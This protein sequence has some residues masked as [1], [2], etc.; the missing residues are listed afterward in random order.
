[1]TTPICSR[2]HTH[3]TKLRRMRGRHLQNTF[4]RGRKG[5]IAKRSCT[6]FPPSYPPC[7][8]GEDAD[9]GCEGRRGHDGNG[10]A[11]KALHVVPRH[12]VHAAPPAVTSRTVATRG[13]WH[14]GGDG[15]GE[16]GGRWLTPRGPT[17]G[18]HKLATKDVRRALV[19]TVVSNTSWGTTGRDRVLH[20]MCQRD[21]R[22]RDTARTSCVPPRTQ[23]RARAGKMNGGLAGA[24]LPLPHLNQ[25]T[26]M[27]SQ[28]A[29]ARGTQRRRRS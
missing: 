7:N 10:R 20:M 9:Q 18:T 29:P 21:D 25:S 23:G 28:R 1:M 17:G 27:K 5:T 14:I 11:Q 26:P 12:S 15:N 3:T 24:L 13:L 8:L 4:T 19:V 2:N 16:G 6:P 22:R